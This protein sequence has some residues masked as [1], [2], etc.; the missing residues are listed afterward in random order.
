M[1]GGLAADQR[2]AG[3]RARGRDAAHHVRDALGH[4]PPAR[5]VVGHEQRPRADHHDVVDDHADQVEPDGVVHVHRLR[6][7]DLGADTVGGRRE[8]RPAVAR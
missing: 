6:D 7:R 4:D 3:D 2:G 8:Q 1:L 5:D